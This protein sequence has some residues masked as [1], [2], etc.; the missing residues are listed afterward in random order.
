MTSEKTEEYPLSIE[1]LLHRVMADI[2]VVEKTGYNKSQNFYHRT[3]D[4][5]MNAA[6]RALIAHGVVVLPRVLDKTSERVATKGGG[7]AQ[8]VELTVAYTFI[9]HTGDSLTAT[10]AAES[11]DYGDKATS[12]AMSMALKVALLQ[13]L[14][15]PTDEIDPDSETYELDEPPVSEEEV[16]QINNWFAHI[17]DKEQR[18]HAKKQ[19]MDK[20]AC[21]P[22]ELKANRM[23]D[24]YDWA[25]AYMA[26]LSVEEIGD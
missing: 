9:G 3:I 22:I 18:K 14:M 25:G 21:P 8:R 2:G 12:K 10:V 19:F 24:F 20:F 23:S 17:E 1:V 4:D 11:I 7:S 5:T 16:K 13:S 26:E 6:H 15:I